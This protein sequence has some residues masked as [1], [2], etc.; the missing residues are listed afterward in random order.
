MYTTPIQYSGCIACT[1]TLNGVVHPAVTLTYVDNP[2]KN[3]SM[4]ALS[5][6]DA[7]RLATEITA[8]FARC[9]HDGYVASGE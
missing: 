3:I 5:L 2:G 7:Q 1:Y 4:R 8:F 6:E 9:A